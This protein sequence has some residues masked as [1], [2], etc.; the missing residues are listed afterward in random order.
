MIWKVLARWA[1]AVIAVP[2]AVAGV[3]KLSD[4]VETRRGS[5]RATRLMRQSADA[6]QTLFGRPKR[7]RRWWRGSR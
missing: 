7:R 6:V 5:N 3:R 1:I 2:L 4:A